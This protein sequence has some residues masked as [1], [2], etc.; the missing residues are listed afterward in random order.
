MQDQFRVFKSG[1]GSY[2]IV[3]P[4]IKELLRQH[5]SRPVGARV[6]LTS[7]TLDIK[8]IFEERDVRQGRGFHRLPQI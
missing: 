3:A 1:A 6:T 2:D 4:K 7:Q 8:R 5:R